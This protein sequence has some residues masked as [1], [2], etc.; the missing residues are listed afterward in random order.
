VSRPTVAIAHDW[1]V[2]YAGSERVVEELLVEF[3]GS[4][5]LTT[6]LDPTTVPEALRRAEPSVLQR[7]PGAT[8]HHEWLVPLMPLAWRLTAPLEADVVVSSSHACAK[9]VRAAPGTPHVCYCHTP[10]RYA[11]DFPAEADRFPAPLRPLASPAMRWF[12]RW[13]RETSSRVTTFV[14]NSSAVAGR[15]GRYYGRGSVVV[16]PPVRT[17]FFTPGPS[18]DEGFFLH[19]SRLAG[20]K[21]GDLVVE[22]FAE[23]DHPLVVVGE[24]PERHRLE[25]SATPNVSFAGQVDDEALRD[26]YRGAIALVYPADED[27]GIVMAEAQACGT[28]V[29]A[30]RA[31]GALDIVEDGATGILI[32]SRDAVALR[33]AVREAAGAHF[34]REAISGKAQRFS[35]ERFRAE[36]RQIVEEAAQKRA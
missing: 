36:I 17:G 25:A 29:V 3:P 16:H 22:A 14:A 4:R 19:V 35:P 2:R 27:F 1:L 9:A 23:L 34:D 13:D 33:S 10:M 8:R 24:G 20:Y 28:P 6:L 18:T 11:W 5:L 30:L 12:R 21:R 31:G 26:L 15:I 7:I 32:D